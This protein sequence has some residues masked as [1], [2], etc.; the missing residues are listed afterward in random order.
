MIVPDANLLLYAYR[1]EVAFHDPA[2]AWWESLLNGPERV[3][4]PW[5]V[6]AAFVRMI[7]NRSAYRVPATPTQAFDFVNEW[8]DSPNVVTVNPGTRHLVLFRENLE[9]AG[10]GGNLTTDAHIAAL[11]MEHQAEVHTNDRDFARF[12]GLMWRNPIRTSE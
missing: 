5:A 11:A 9:V 8:L 1:E 2:R 3:G 12:P 10:V 4:I 7:T 6:V